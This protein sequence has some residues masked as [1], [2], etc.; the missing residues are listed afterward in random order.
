METKDKYYVYVRPGQIGYF[1][2]L[3]EAQK[4][5][6]YYNSEVKEL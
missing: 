5:A 3:S 1:T 6:K 2:T 4:Y